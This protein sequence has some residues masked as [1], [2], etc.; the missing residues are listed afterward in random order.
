MGAMIPTERKSKNTIARIKVNAARPEDFSAMGEEGEVTRSPQR[1]IVAG[2]CQTRK[3]LL[4]MGSAL[5]P[6]CEARAYYGELYNAISGCR[7]L[8]CCWKQKRLPGQV[9]L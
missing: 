7:Q 9:E 2:K 4:E 1:T 8:L 6:E 5:A 3:K